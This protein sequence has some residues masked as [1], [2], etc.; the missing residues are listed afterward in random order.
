MNT[1]NFSWDKERRGGLVD[2]VTAIYG[3][4]FYQMCEPGRL[5]ILRASTTCYKE[6]AKVI[7]QRDKVII[8]YV[9]QIR[10]KRMKGK[11]CRGA[12]K[13]LIFNKFVLDQLNKTG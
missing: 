4:I 2:N 1:R 12:S 9:E 5:T 3:P 7:L 10:N 8:I 6:G 13:I 11:E